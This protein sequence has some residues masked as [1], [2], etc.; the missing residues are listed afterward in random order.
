MATRRVLMFASEFAAATNPMDAVGTIRPRLWA[1]WLPSNGWTPIVVTAGSEHEVSTSE[2]LVVRRVPVSSVVGRAK[3]RA[4]VSNT[5]RRMARTTDG[6]GQGTPM[7]QVQSF[8]REVASLVPDHLAWVARAA[9][10]GAGLDRLHGVDVVFSTS[11]SPATHLAAWLVAID[12]GLPWVAELRDLWAQLPEGAG[13]TRLRRL[14]DQ[15]AERVLFR[16]ASA[17]VTVS[18]GQA[19]RLRAAYPSLPV[20]PIPTG[21]DPALVSQEDETSSDTFRLVYA[22]RVKRRHDPM[23][24]LRPLAD[25]ITAGHIDA[26]RTRVEFLSMGTLNAKATEFVRSSVLAGVVV[27]E[28]LLPRDEVLRRERL[29]HVLLHLRWDDPEETGVFAAKVF[30][31]L[32]ARRPI[33]STGHFEDEVSR[34]IRESGSGLASTSDEQTKQ[35]L[36]EAFRA[37]ERDG[38]VP[39]HAKPEALRR[40]EAPVTVTRLASVLKAAAE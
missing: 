14:P 17:L 2:H 31:Y 39:Y 8:G 35:F 3:E 21:Y 37:F 9:K 15:V 26:S 4:G 22:G 36:I 25:A 29:A 24:L 18:E 30:E 6:L 5:S 34:V 40:Y 19:D 28:E 7:G 16:R 13:R 20:H 23:M 10:A 38:R 1:R 11:P 33:L 12:R 32:A 27:E